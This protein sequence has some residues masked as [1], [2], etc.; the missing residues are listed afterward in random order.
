MVRKVVIC[1]HGIP[2]WKC[3]EC[4]REYQKQYHRQYRAEKIEKIQKIERKYRDSHKKEH[5]NRQN[6]YRK[7][8]QKKIKVH[9]M[10]NNN[11][12]K[13]PLLNQCEFC[14]NTENLQRHHPDYD[15]PEIYVTVCAFCHRWID[16][17]I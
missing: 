10:M 1:S 17:G 3:T 2:K 4:K 5:S 14:P 15:F 12:D 8:N 7:M 11:P 13:Y 16:R 6:Q 9:Q